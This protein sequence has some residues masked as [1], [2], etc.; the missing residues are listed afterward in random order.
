MTITNGT[1]MALIEQMGA[2]VIFHREDGGASCPCRTPEGFRDPAWH[3]ANPAA[4]VC[5]EQGFLSSVILDIQVRAV[6]NPPR[7]RGNRGSD[8]TNDL[9]GEIQTGDR[10]GIFPCSWQGFKLDFYDWSDAG[11]DFII[12]DGRRYVSVECAKVTDIDGDPN[13][14]WEVGLRLVKTT[15]PTDV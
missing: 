1:V 15:R 12:F 2:P 5:N 10:I 13:G 11:E 14:H 7:M 4:P 3:R 8:R 9:L 6:I